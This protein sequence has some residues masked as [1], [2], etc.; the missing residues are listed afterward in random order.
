MNVSLRTISG[1][2]FTYEVEPTTTVGEI[3]A[4]ASKDTETPAEG[5]KLIYA[6]KFLEDAQVIGECNIQPGQCIIMHIQNKNAKNVGQ[7]KVAKQK[8]PKKESPIKVQEIAKPPE[9]APANPVSEKPANP[10]AAPLPTIESKNQ[11]VD[12]PNFDE[13]VNQLMEMGFTEGDSIHALRAAVYN[14]D[15]AAEFLL[16]NYIPELPHLYDPNEHPEEADLD[17]YDYE[18]EFEDEQ[19]Q[20]MQFIRL[21]HKNPQLLPIYLQ[22]LADNNPAIAPLIYND[23]ASF[24]VSLGLNPSEFDLTGFKRKSQFESLMSRFSEEEQQ[25]IHRLEK[26]GFDTTDVIQVFEACDRNEELT[27]SCLEGM[28]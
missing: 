24:L 16:T 2:L 25:A 12:P 8:S 10:K 13:L 17:D 22:D 11:L 19:A 21:L 27:K 9:P 3:R 6:A 18:E 7:K 4:M 26:L 1:K 20:T 15:R 14:P 5:I 28:K 23:P